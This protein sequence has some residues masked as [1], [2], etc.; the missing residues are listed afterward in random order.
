MEF[1]GVPPWT[2]TAPDPA[3]DDYDSSDSLLETP[4]HDD[5]SKHGKSGKY[6]KN[7]KKDNKE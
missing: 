1:A 6:K 3:T 4:S 7:A 2:P 5:E